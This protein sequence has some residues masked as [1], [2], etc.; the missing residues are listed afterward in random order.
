M[1]EKIERFNQSGMM[2]GGT[3]IGA[4]HFTSMKQ[5]VLDLCESRYDAKIKKCCNEQ[6]IEVR[7]Y[8]STDRYAS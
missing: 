7:V 2:E 1:V 8:T 4:K 3:T 5:D 6:T